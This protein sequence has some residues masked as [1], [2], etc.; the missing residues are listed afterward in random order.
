MTPQSPIP[1]FFLLLCLPSQIVVTL[2]SSALM[3]YRPG[4][5]NYFPLTQEFPAFYETLWLIIFSER[6]SRCFLR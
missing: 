6:G 4:E 1:Y 2:D 5:T 3:E